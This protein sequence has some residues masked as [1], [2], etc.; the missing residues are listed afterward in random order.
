MSG[1]E[2]LSGVQS[3][4]PYHGVILK[5]V[6]PEGSGAYRHSSS[7]CVSAARQILRKLRMT[8]S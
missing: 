7:E 5:D 8:P 3:D 1:D 2:D 6:S 4:F